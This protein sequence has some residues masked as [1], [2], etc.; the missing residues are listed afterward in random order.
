MAELEATIVGFNNDE[1]KE[2][3][4]VKDYANAKLMA[5]A[6]RDIQSLLK[7][8]QIEPN[9]AANTAYAQKILDY[10]RD[11]KE[12]I[13][14]E[15]WQRIMDYLDALQPVIIANNVRKI[16]ETLIEEGIPTQG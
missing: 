1:V 14:F 7:G 8:K 6:E 5:E 13:K 9:A 16:D 12:N 3:L 4:D 11:N 2:L 15:V 10:T